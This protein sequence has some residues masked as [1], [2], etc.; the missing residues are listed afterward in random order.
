MLCKYYEYLSH[1]II[2]KTILLSSHR[3]PSQAIAKLI[4]SYIKNQYYT[5]YL[6]RSI[7]TEV[8][9]RK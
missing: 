8:Y 9:Y 2:R 3:F 5:Y 6:H 7:I 4:L 1:T